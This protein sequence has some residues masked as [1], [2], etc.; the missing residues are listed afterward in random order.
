MAASQINSNS[1]H[2]GAQKH[3]QLIKTKETLQRQQLYETLLD[4]YG[5]NYCACQNKHC[6]GH[7]NNKF[8]TLLKVNQLSHPLLREFIQIITGSM[9][10]KSATFFKYFFKFL[11]EQDLNKELLD[12]LLQLFVVLFLKS[13]ESV[14]VTVLEDLEKVFNLL[15]RNETKIFVDRNYKYKVFFFGI[16]QF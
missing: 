8:R 13:E 5:D 4:L 11:E 6:K 16:S 9:M 15:K 1:I 3:T 12:D 10:K 2:N 7:L 14:Q